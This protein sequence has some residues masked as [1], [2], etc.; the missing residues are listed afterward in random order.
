MPKAFLLIILVAVILAIVVT[1]VQ[2]ES[3]KPAAHFVNYENNFHSSEFFEIEELITNEFQQIDNKQKNLYWTQIGITS[4][5]LPT[6]L[7]FIADFYRTLLNSE[8]PRDTFVILGPDHFERC[9]APVS[10]TKKSYLTPFGELLPDEEIINALL[11]V[12]VS[13]DD[14]CFKGE[15]SIGVQTIFIK[16]LFPNVKIVPLT[17][18]ATIED[19]IIDN[20]ADVLF[21]YQDR[22][23]VISSIDFSHYQ[24]Y[25]RAIQLDQISEQMIEKLAGFSFDLEHVDSPACIKLAIS[26]A[27]KIGSDKP[28]ILGRANS[29][30]FTGQS[31][32]TTG[33][34]NILFIDHKKTVSPITLMFVGDIMLSRA[35]GD[36]M[37]K[38]NDWRWPFL[39]IADDL[40]EAD[41][42]FGNLEGPISDRG[43]NVGSKYSF[44]ADP[45]VVE[46]LKYAGFD[47]LSV[48][49]NHMGDW[50]RLALEDT[51]RIL[52]DNDISYAGGGFNEAEAHS[53]AVKEIRGTRFAF[54][55]YTSLG[56]KY[57]E[58][59]GE[60]SGIAFADIER[61]TEDI[62]TARERADLVIVSF[63]FGGEY[64]K[65]PTELQKKVARA[66]VEAGASLV[67][68]HHPH[69]VQE[70]E[71]YQG[72]YIAY[73]LGNFIFDQTFSK[74][75]TEGL[76]LKATVKDK[77]INS[78]EPIKI[79]ISKEFQV[80]V[81]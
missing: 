9:Y 23:T 12:D 45:R 79:K 56:P 34:M 75:T 68:G 33:Y 3:S 18:S 55:A 17:F 61:L 59:K 64:A 13:I 28:L 76:L 6:A 29:Y 20:I 41:L 1:I 52:A 47:V 19:N 38:I 24:P 2:F 42:L 73:S 15:H 58:A 31:E 63:H 21:G 71:E 25:I 44:R 66:A 74:E 48:A 46:G 50:T 51:F 62:K 35:V 39:E 32:N 36:K 11:G 81:E 65:E 16:Y 40:Q 57:I 22:I 4:H 30:D 43:K 26:L 60:N 70:I 77:K 53:P 8:G 49:N 80:A 54:L 5:H 10:V 7:P 72:G 78:I 14:E 67:V 37:K 27:K 69:V